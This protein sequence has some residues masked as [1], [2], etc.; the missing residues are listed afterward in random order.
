MKIK[1]AAS[2]DFWS[3]LTALLA[4]KQFADLLGVFLPE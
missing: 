1:A 4:R 2:R 3:E